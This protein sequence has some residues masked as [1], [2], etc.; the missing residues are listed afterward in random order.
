MASPVFGLNYAE[1]VCFAIKLK[2]HIETD[3]IK[4]RAKLAYAAC[5]IWRALFIEYI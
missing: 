5:M 2:L 4:M 1:N 3:V